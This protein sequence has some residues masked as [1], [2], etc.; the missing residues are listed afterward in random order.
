[1]KLYLDANAHVSLSKA[2]LSAQAAFMNSDA[3]HGHPSSPS[4]TGRAAAA[5]LEEARAK[6]AKLINAPSAKHIIFTNSCTQACEWAMRMLERVPG[7]F[8]ISPVEH[9]AVTQGCEAAIGQIYSKLH[10]NENGEVFPPPNMDDFGSIACIHMQNEIGSIQ[11]IQ[12]FKNSFP[13]AKLF[14]DISQSLGKEPV[15]VLHMRVDFAAAGGHKFGGPGGIGFLFVKDLDDWTHFGS[16]SRYFMDIPGT[17]NVLGAVMMAAALEEAVNTLEHRRANMVAFRDE[18]EPK[19]KKLGFQIVGE[20]FERCPNTTFVKSPVSSLSVL[21][22]LG[23]HG[24]HCGLGSACGSLYTGGSPVMRALGKESDAEDYM[25]ISQ[26]G[27]YREKEAQYVID[28]INKL[29]SQRI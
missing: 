27:E 13:K 20:E 23:K 29:W 19:L 8:Y 11:N 4:V 17:P 22:E 10:V 14:S 7:P 28:T 3:A 25:R 18:L 16:G 12:W 9:P 21:L 24:I 5:A 15:N 2:A 6:I 1:M 26:W